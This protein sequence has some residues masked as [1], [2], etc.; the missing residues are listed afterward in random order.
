MKKVNMS[1]KIIICMVL[2]AAIVI[3]IFMT[4]IGSIR[5]AVTL[6]GHPIVAMQLKA[7][8]ITSKL[9]YVE[10]EGNQEIYCISNPPTD[11][12]TS[13]VLENWAVYKYGVFYITQYFGFA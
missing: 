5:L 4:P 12:K 9:D 6:S 11:N 10:L 3:Y 2:I 7:T 8:N 1:K 13:C